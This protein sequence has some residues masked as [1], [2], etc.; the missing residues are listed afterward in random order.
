MRVRIENLTSGPFYYLVCLAYMAYPDD[1]NMR[2]QLGQTIVATTA[3]QLEEGQPVTLSSET[4]SGLLA[5][6]KTGAATGLDGACI[7]GMMAGE[8]L[9]YLLRMRNSGVTNPSLDKA[10]HLASEFFGTTR[11]HGGGLYRGTGRDTVRKNWEKFR[12][13]AHLWAAYTA[14]VQTC[15]SEKDRGEWAAARTGDVLSMAHAICEDATTYRPPDAI[16]TVL[17]S[18]QTWRLEGVPLVPYWLRPLTAIEIKQLES[19]VPRNR[20]KKF[21]PVDKPSMSN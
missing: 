17:F 4:M 1:E 10:Q 6:A 2:E 21:S 18:E 16:E 8:V 14:I 19:F 20:G 3:T 5:A 9:L 7:G 15:P 12:S 11:Q 13:V